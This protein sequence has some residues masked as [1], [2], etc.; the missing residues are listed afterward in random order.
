MNFENRVVK[1]K[2]GL[3]KME[4]SKYASHGAENSRRYTAVKEFLCC[5]LNGNSVILN[6]STGKYYGV[7]SVGSF[8]WSAIQ[9]PKSFDEVRD[10]VLAEYDVDEA[11]CDE[12]VSAFLDK[13]SDQELVIISDD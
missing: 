4:S 5:D 8:I 7:N 11:V 2:E 3:S 1:F 13:M 10:L 9:S 12:E 6:I